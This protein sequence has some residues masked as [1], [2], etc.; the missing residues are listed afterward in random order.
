MK[1]RKDSFYCGIICGICRSRVVAFFGRCMQWMAGE[2]RKVA[3]ADGILIV[4]LTSFDDVESR[5][6]YVLYALVPGT[7]ELPSLITDNF[8]CNSVE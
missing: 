8:C 7:M 3:P 2:A 6:N 4:V 1:E 5:F